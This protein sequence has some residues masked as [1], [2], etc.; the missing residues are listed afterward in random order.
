[1]ITAPTFTWTAPVTS[2]TVASGQVAT[3]NFTATP[4]GGATTFAGTVTFACTGLPAATT[5]AFTPTQI[6]AGAGATPVQVAISTSGPNPATPNQL[7]RVSQKQSPWLPLALPLAGI[8]LVGFAG[9]KMSKHSAIAGLL[10]SMLLLAL[11]VAC[12]GGGGGSS[13]P[14]IS[15]AVSQGVPPSVY[16]NNTGWPSQTAQFSATVSNSSN[17]A[18]TWSVATAN[19]GTISS[20][21]LYTAPMVVA[22]LPTSVTI[23]AT[24]AADTTK[25]GS[26]S[27]TLT[28][29][30][31]PGTY[32]VTVTA[33]ESTTVVSTPVTLI[34]Q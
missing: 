5:C 34:V 16:P 18:V 19:G 31:V 8:V 1:V 21:G 7:R 15:V 2:A 10:V 22:G 11:L 12:G 25:S 4:K 14:P 20:S 27:E 13:T 9:R 28:P 6:A 32:T 33:T 29:A 23:T 24:S 3:Y 17:T 26:A 30:T